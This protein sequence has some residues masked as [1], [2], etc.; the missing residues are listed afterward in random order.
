MSLLLVMVVTCTITLLKCL[1]NNAYTYT[2]AINGDGPD[3]VLPPCLIIELIL[4][5]K[6]HRKEQRST[7]ENSQEVNITK[8]TKSK[9]NVVKK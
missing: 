7:L 1:M 9:A 4:T 5:H 2:L 6:G 8:G 3:L